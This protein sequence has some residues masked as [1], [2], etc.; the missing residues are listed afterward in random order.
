LKFS[1]IVLEGTRDS[2]F[3]K[4]LLKRSLSRSNIEFK[5]REGNSRIAKRIVS[6]ACIITYSNLKTI[7][8]IPVPGIN[9]LKKLRYVLLRDLSNPQMDF[10]DIPEVILDSRE[11]FRRHIPKSDLEAIMFVCDYDRAQDLA[12]DKI[13][14][15]ASLY[16]Y[17]KVYAGVLVRHI[18]FVRNLE[19]FLYNRMIRA[20]VID[21]N[22]IVED[23]LQKGFS[24][25]KA[26]KAALFKYCDSIYEQ[27]SRLFSLAEAKVLDEIL[28]EISELFLRINN[29]VS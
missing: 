12:T 11:I 1:I 14:K 28:T 29:S 6:G 7:V 24:L 2:I 22:E 15:K 20:G 25:T 21:L 23:L 3:L 9:E 19:E 8:L 10:V 27:Y 5:I 13:R 17:D 18:F 4:Y 26:V 16:F